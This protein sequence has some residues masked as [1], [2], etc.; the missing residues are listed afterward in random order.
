MTM[1][2][3]DL[4]VKWFRHQG[5]PF[6]PLVKAVF[7]TG[8]NLAEVVALGVLIEAA[9]GEVKI[10]FHF[11]QYMTTLRKNIWVVHDPEGTA[12][13]SA[14]MLDPAPFRNTYGQALT[15]TQVREAD[16]PKP[17]IAGGETV[18]DY[19][20]GDTRAGIIDRALAKGWQFFGEDVLLRVEIQGDILTSAENRKDEGRFFARAKIIAVS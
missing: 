20:Y 15:E 10:L 12:P 4:N 14:L 8:D 6:K 13:G 3:K 7:Y 2:G 5:D 1:L 17:E 9:H 16:A 19:V 18:T 11:G